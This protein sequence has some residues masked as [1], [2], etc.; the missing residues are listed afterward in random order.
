LRRAQAVEEAVAVAVLLLGQIPGLVGVASR[1]LLTRGVVG[2]EGGADAGGD[3][4]AQAVEQQ[5]AV[6]QLRQPGI[7]LPRSGSQADHR[8]G[9]ANP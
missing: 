6:R 7:P 5:A 4:P 8:P 2:A 3:A 9:G 1:L